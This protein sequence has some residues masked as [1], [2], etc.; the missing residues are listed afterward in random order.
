MQQRVCLRVFGW[1]LRRLS[2]RSSRL[3]DLSIAVAV[4]GASEPEG[5]FFTLRPTLS[6]TSY[7]TAHGFG[8][9]S[10]ACCLSAALS[11]KRAGLIASSHATYWLP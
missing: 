5:Y 11:T 2:C 3:N 6:H 10:R 1:F 4:V 7:D 9:G 8:L